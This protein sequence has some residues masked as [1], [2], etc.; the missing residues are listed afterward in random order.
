[1]LNKAD[2]SREMV[3]E[4]EK[5]VLMAQCCCHYLCRAKI[6]DIKI[7]AEHI[8]DRPYKLLFKKKTDG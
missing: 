4:G 2:E 6:T 1:L 7:I 3:G 8:Y 5:I